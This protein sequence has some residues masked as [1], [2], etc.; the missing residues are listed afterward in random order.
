MLNTK[1]KAM[2][3][4]LKLENE[5]HDLSA[6]KSVLG[7]DQETYMPERGIDGRAYSLSTLEVTGHKKFTRKYTGKLIKELESVVI[8]P[9]FSDYDR[10]LVRNLKRDYEQKIKLP[11][12]FVKEFSELAS[13][14]T[15]TWKKARNE[16]NFSVFAPYLEKIVGM[17][18]KEAKYL[19]YQQFPYDVL[20]EQY[21][22][23]M[24]QAKLENIF[25]ELKQYTL[26]TLE[27]IKQ[28]NVKPKTELLKVH[29]PA[30]KQLDFSRKVV[31][32]MGF[33]FSAGRMDQSAH[34]FTSSSH[35]NDVRITTRID[36][37]YLSTCLTSCIHETGHALY[38]QGIDIG[39]ARTRLADGASYGFHESQSRL[40][41]NY[42]GKSPAFWRFWFDKLKGVSPENLANVNDEEFV[43]AMNDV[44]PSLIR[45]E[46]DEVTYNLHIILRF[47]IEKDLING[48]I[49]VKDIPTVWNNKMK[50]YLGIVPE[51]DSA[52]CLQDIHWACGDFGYFPTYS[53][54]NMY[55]AQIYH[56]LCEEYP[57]LDEKVARGDL[58]FIRK[59][60]ADK[61]HKYGKTYQPED[62]IKMV[63]GE[64]LNP[65]YFREYLKRKFG[66]IY[67]F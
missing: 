34:P 44:A 67:N 50:E 65:K 61:I 48:E 7:W 53:L 54:G 47:E 51:S 66:K 2:K 4:L 3:K 42:I 29:Y 35:P 19:G 15:E 36:E 24:T 18:R 40:W 38:E 43:L 14:A 32:S 59:W 57:D 12:K 49:E 11:A 30:E 16:N 22:P 64:E 20:L 5:L 10:A 8:G 28:S 45:T 63:T 6:A 26:E 62:L 55:A 9:E 60:L 31:E 27:K 41:E 23:G 1:N 39:L 13:R 25:S 37:N 56:R 21:E 17:K 46:A 58:L 52:G 33:D